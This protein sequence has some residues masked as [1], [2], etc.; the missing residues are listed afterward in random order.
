MSQSS[1]HDYVEQHQHG[2]TKNY[3]TGFFLSVILTLIPF[4]MVMNH[5]ASK[6]VLFG[7]IVAAAVIQLV[8]Q[9]VFFLHLG[10][11]PDER[12]NLISFIFT[13]IVIVLLVGLSIWI[14]WSLNANMVM[15]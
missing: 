13:A 10:T 15:G 9:L 3:L 1:H 5:S 7:V 8:V 11:S 6:T 4:L 2:S 14:M 12:W